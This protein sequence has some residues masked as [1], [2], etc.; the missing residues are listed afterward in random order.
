MPVGCV[1]EQLRQH[2]VTSRRQAHSR[3]RIPLVCVE[4]RRNHHELGFE[5]IDHWN[6]ER[7]EDIEKIASVEPASRGIF[8][9]KPAPFPRPTS[10]AAPVPG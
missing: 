7:V 6:D 10:S 9:V 4:A 5:L 3:E 8:S 1:A 2:R